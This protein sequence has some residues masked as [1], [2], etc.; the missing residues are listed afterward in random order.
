MSALDDHRRL[1][2]EWARLA[3]LSTN[4]DNA[5]DALY[6]EGA[7]G[8][9]NTANAEMPI[10]AAFA[11]RQIE[12]DLFDVACYEDV[13][14]HPTPDGFVVQYMQVFAKDG[15]QFHIPCV[16][17]AEVSDG[18]IARTWTYRDSAADAPVFKILMDSGAM[19]AFGPM[20]GEG[21]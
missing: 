15:E 18:R 2:E 3:D 4:D 11:A 1:G 19:D 13:V 7:T 17:V 21:S 10:R 6:A 5:L 14:V 9:V 12:R 20:A 16:Q 8:W